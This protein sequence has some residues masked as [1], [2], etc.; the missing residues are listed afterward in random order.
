MRSLSLAE[1]LWDRFFQVF[2]LVLIGTTE[3]DGSVDLA[4]KHMAMPLSWK[5]HFGFVCTPAHATYVNARRESV[6][7]VSYPRPE[8]VVATSLSAAPRD[9]D[10]DKPAL[11]ALATVPAR[12][13][14]GHL[15]AGAYL[16]LECELDRVVDDLGDNSLIVGRIVAAAIAED[17]ARDPEVDDQDLIAASPLLSYVAPGRYAQ[18]AR[19]GAFPFHVGFKR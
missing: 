17:C 8:Q 9:V 15:L 18:V 11:S 13:V 10:G 7:T 12:R 3:P 1:P 5:H 16:H 2:P 14:S 19:T 6:F 4:P